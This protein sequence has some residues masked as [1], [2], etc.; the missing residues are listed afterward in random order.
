MDIEISITLFYLL[1]TN[2]WGNNIMGKATIDD[3]AIL[4][5]VSIKTVSR[6][7]NKEGN[8]RAKTRERVL[9]A[10]RSLQYQPSQ[11]ARGL[12]GNRSYMIGMIYSH[13]SPGYLMDV[14]Q[15]VL[16]TCNETHYGL[17]L[18]PIDHKSDDAAQKL[19][20]WLRRSGVDGVVL[21][22]PFGS[23]P[24]VIEVLK[25]TG[26]PA[27]ALSEHAL[28]NVSSVT[29]DEVS[30]ARD[31]TRHL[32]REGHTRIAFIKGEDDH[33]S[34]TLRLQGFKEEMKEHDLKV[35][36]TLIASGDFT[37]EGSFGAIESLLNAQK[38]VSAVFAANDDMAAAV[39]SIAHKRGIKVPDE[40]AVV[41]FD[42]SPIAAQVWPALTTVD[43]PVEAMAS[44]ASEQ[45][46]KMIK[47]PVKRG[48]Q[49][50][51]MSVT[52][53][54]EDSS[55]YAQTVVPYS[56]HVRRSSGIFE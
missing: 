26:T 46:I 3:V 53:E 37:Y 23:D 16:K 40:L 10:V 25:H 34:S 27:I 31:L 19:E 44:L 39:L 56:M 49:D 21:T 45:L 48:D 4:A 18:G 35:E 8:V 22:P 36:D 2:K 29:V 6:V 42:N 51:S 55:D 32:I 7:I 41:G 54:H 20:S 50:T 24:T 17:A 5:G 43:Q 30:A 13:L 12:A 11:S 1:V 14:Q 33:Q 9:E 47:A 28:D 15:G 38:S 52:Q